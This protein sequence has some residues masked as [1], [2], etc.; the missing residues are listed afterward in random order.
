MV[1][2]F[3]WR[4]P[5]R[6]KGLRSRDC[7]GS[8]L[9]Q[10][11]SGFS[12]QGGSACSPPGRIACNRRAWQ[13]QFVGCGQ[14]N[15][16]VAWIQN[17]EPCAI[18]GCGR[19]PPLDRGSWTSARKHPRAPCT[20]HQLHLLPGSLA[21]SNQPFRSWVSSVQRLS[22]GKRSNHE[23]LQALDAHDARP[24]LGEAT[25]QGLPGST[26]TESSLSEAQADTAL[27]PI[28]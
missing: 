5:V 10:R 7:R 26:T 3:N 8:V 14:E 9:F 22:L 6:T 20:T 24:S 16:R 23:Q 12:T 21:R 19:T 15:S 18:L 2:S 1:R 28:R 4:S 27:G 13:V 17:V 25:V 11:Q